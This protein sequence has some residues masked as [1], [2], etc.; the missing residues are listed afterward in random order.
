MGA[1]PVLGIV[2]AVL[3]LLNV[4]IAISIG[5]AAAAALLI[6]GNF[7]M[8]VLAQTFY[9]ATDS[10]S[11]MAI[12]F[13]MLAGSLM[14]LG[15]IS[16]RLIDFAEACVGHRKGGIGTVTVICCMIFAAISGSGPATVAAL[17]GILI[18]AM[19]RAKYDAG[20][21]SALMA[22]AG[23]I[24]IIIPPSIP[25][26]VY[27]VQ[28][29][30]SVGTMFMTGMV[31]G[32]LIGLA[33]IFYNKYEAK[34]H[35]FV[36][37][38]EPLPGKERVRKMITAIPALMMPVIILGGIYTGICTATEAAGVSVL[39]GF[40]VGKFIY[41]DLKWKDIPEILVKASVSSATIMFIIM[42][43]AIF[44]YVIV[45]NSLPQA[46]VAWTQAT[47]NN[48][49]VIL[50]AI[51]ILL[52]IAGCFLDASSAIIILT[53]LMLPLVQQYGINVYHFGIIVV[54]NLA[55]GLITPPVGL[56]LFVACNISKI[57]VSQLV[58]RLWGCLI[59]SLIVLFLITY[60]P[61]IPLSLPRLFGAAGV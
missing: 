37:N 51:N 9:T 4:P 31:P 8:S 3:L 15:G 10:I 53:P 40:I 41:R 47:V 61:I 30:A 20:Y 54:F 25:M 52:L 27:A 56:D 14:E 6:P 22:T 57:G 50:L 48:K 59:I 46:V 23:G 35:G 1:I 32:L 13:F 19:M 44:S 49:Y 16:Q 29:E 11:L 24:G 45:A 12:P 2:L 39:Y 43:A 33:L 60:V 34:K 5:L 58:K 38:E 17:G 42:C 18:P 7:P 55:I 26:I 28:A 36:G 21:A